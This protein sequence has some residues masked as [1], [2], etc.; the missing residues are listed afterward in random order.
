MLDDT[1]LLDLAVEGMM[2]EPT[3][4]VDPVDPEPTPIVKQVQVL[5]DGT[6]GP[7]AETCTAGICQWNNGD[8]VALGSAAV[9][10]TQSEMI[11]VVN[12]TECPADRDCADCQVTLGSASQAALTLTA[13][14]NNAAWTLSDENGVLILG[15]PRADC[16]ALAP[17]HLRSSSAGD[18]GWQL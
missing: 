13:A 1:L 9:G 3:D 2:P 5:I 7:A 4:V 10:A 14:D 18:L 16:Q 12:A 6:V 17:C 11:R 8:A 15:A